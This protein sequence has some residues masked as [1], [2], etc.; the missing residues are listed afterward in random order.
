MRGLSTVIGIVLIILG[1][2][3]LAYGRISYT[4]HSKAADIGPLEVRM[5]EKERVPIPPVLGVVA[6]AG[7]VVL[8]AVGARTRS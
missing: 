8:V 2:V 5:E 6:L 7:G 1:V 3:G 4:K